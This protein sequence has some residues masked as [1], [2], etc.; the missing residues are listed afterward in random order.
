MGRIRS[1]SYEQTAS[2]GSVSVNARC[3][4]DGA[5]ARHLGLHELLVLGRL[6]ALVGRHHG[7]QAFLLL[8]ERCGQVPRELPAN[9][10]CA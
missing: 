9:S 1:A 10:L 6:D 7:A 4:D 8:D 5:E 3:F 2:D